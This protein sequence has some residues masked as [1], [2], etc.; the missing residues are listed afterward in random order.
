MYLLSHSCD[1]SRNATLGTNGRRTLQALY[2]GISCLAIPMDA[3]TSIQNGFELGRGYDFFF[4]DGQ[5]VKVGDKLTLSGDTYVVG[6][7]QKYVVPVVA[8]VHAMA[9]QGVN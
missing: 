8:Y 3:Q 2:T 4:N 9:K 5:D 1:I 7:V 6:A